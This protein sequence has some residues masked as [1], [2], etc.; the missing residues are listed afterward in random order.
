M[1]IELHSIT[2]LKSCLLLQDIQNYFC[3]LC[4]LERAADYSLRDI[5]L[6]R[7]FEALEAAPQVLLAFILR[8]RGA[9]GRGHHLHW[10]I[11]I[12]P[13]HLPYPLFGFDGKIVRSKSGFLTNFLSEKSH[14]HTYKNCD[15]PPFFQFL[16]ELYLSMFYISKFIY[17]C[18]YRISSDQHQ[19][20]SICSYLN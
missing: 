16:V 12:E 2:R 7:L 5:T 18:D 10:P 14:K 6:L 11:D 20:C 13:R 1:F 8:G 9:G 3:K 17:A 19:K 15:D 4:L